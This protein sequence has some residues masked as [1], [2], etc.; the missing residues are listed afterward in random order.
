MPKTKM[1]AEHKEALAAGREQGRAVAAYLDA[2]E[3]NKPRRGRKRTPESIQKRLSLINEEYETVSSIK[4]LQL[5][6][7]RRDLERELA[8]LANAGS[9]DDVAAAEKS[10]LKVAK[11]YAES[12]GISYAAWREIGVPADVLKKAGISRSGS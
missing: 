7:E 6:Q 11:A 8:S 12:K 3:S 4:A 9:G 2:L 1:T 10:F 5:I